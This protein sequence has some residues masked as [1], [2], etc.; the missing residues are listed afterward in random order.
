MFTKFT[1]DIRLGGV[2]NTIENKEDLEI[3]EVWSKWRPIDIQ[4]KADLWKAL[5]VKIRKLQWT[6]YNE[7]VV[8]AELRLNVMVTGVS[9]TANHCVILPHRLQGEGDLF[10]LSWVSAL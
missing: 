7:G 10:V 5:H 4:E 2:T 3:L 6:E 9:R 8:A 1:E